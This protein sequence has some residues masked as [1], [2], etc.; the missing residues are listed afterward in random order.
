V[1]EA[2]APGPR[3]DRP[4]GPVHGQLTPLP[5]AVPPRGARSRPSW[6]P[7]SFSAPL[8]AAALRHSG[9][10]GP[11]HAFCACGIDSRATSPQHVSRWTAPAVPHR[12]EP[13]IHRPARPPCGPGRLPGATPHLKT[14]PSPEGSDRTQAGCRER[15]WARVVPIPMADGAPS[16]ALQARDPPRPRPVV[17]PRPLPPFPPVRPLAARPDGVSSVEG[18]PACALVSIRT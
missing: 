18:A 12:P 4:L 9:P 7:P 14:P 2:P 6:L 16:S 17:V 1:Q 8:R 10:R 3:P 11:I 5:L 13:D 15:R